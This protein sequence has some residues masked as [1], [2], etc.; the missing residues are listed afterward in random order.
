M[1]Q[2]GKTL[3]TSVSKLK[4]F[5]TT[6]LKTLNF[7]RMR[8]LFLPAVLC[9]GLFGCTNQK[10]TNWNQYLGPNRNV[11]ADGGAIAREWPSEGPVKAWEF[12]LGPGYG[13]ASIYNGEVFVLDRIVGESDVLRCIDLTTG[14]EKWNYTYEASGELPYPGSRAVPTVDEN[15]VWCVGPRGHFNCIDKKTHQPVWSHNLLDEYGGEL[16]NWGFSLSPII[17]GDLAI[18]APQGEKAGVV[19]FH[20]LTG[21]VVWESRKLTGVRF[22]VSPTLG[23]YGGKDQV[24]MI[25]SNLKGDGLTGDEV[26][27][28][29]ANT[30]KE[31]W[32]YEGLN[33]FACIAP[34]LVIDENKLFLTTCAYK[35]KY[36]PVSIL[37]EIS[38]VG[39]DFQ[40]K[41]IFVNEEAGCKMHPPVFVNDHFYINNNGNPGEL[42]CLNLKGEK[43]WE[44]G[45]APD[46]EMGS[47]IL[48]DGLIINQNGKNGDIHLIEPSPEGYKE[49]GKASFFDS[50]KSQAWSPMAF[51][52]GKLLIRNLE[53]MV[54][55][56]L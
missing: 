4:G 21:E 11:T 53:K 1:Q 27:A 48:V 2:P 34:P 44:K 30:G 36:D 40:L 28:F 9:L 35:D 46:F 26:V 55:V 16:Q 51:S 33:S 37:L 47:V 3:Q 22:H 19:A 39:E 31:L 14:V 12:D 5:Q 42:V 17:Y 18:V 41:E 29:E 6:L 15:Y 25:S 13:G 50:A 8:S 49:L 45:T 52:N 10:N 32:R 54:C 43:V 24:I 7:N 20:K 56:N 38:V 23:N